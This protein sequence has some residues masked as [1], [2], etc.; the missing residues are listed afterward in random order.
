L[1]RKSIFAGV[2]ISLLALLPLLM[3]ACSAGSSPVT[4]TGTPTQPPATG[5][6]GTTINLVAQ[7]L[8]FNLKTISV[9]AGVQVT[10]N[11]NN[12]D[13]GIQHNFSVYQQVSGGQ[14]KAVFVGDPVLGPG[15]KTYQFTAPKDSTATYYFYC[16]F[17]P[18]S[19][20]GTFVV[21]P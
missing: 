20:T 1:R 2:F 10:V 19:M 12:M 11:L 21:I 17:H 13:S 3:I 6:N 5:A 18:Q 9:P 14:A 7:N 15:I 4:Q 8:A 16:D